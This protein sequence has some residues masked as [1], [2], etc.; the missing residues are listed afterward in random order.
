MDIFVELWT[1]SH[2]T[3]TLVALS[4]TRG[5]DRSGAASARRWPLMRPVFPALLNQSFAPWPGYGGRIVK[6]LCLMGLPELLVLPRTGCIAQTHRRFFCKDL[7][8]AGGGSHGANHLL[9]GRERLPA[10]ER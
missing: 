8:P 5:M 10:S 7:L 9:E 2:R 6:A 3:T 1:A 4:E